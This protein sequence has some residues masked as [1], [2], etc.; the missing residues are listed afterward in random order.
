MISTPRRDPSVPFD[1]IDSHIVTA[2]CIGVWPEYTLCSTSIVWADE[3]LP[4]VVIQQ[5][6][7]PLRSDNHWKF[8]L[9]DAERSRANNSRYL[10]RGSFASC[11]TL[12]DRAVVISTEGN[13]PLICTRHC[14]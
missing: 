8:C 10:G 9:Q 14:Q 2:Y 7:K 12:G 3:G 13:I 5:T 1:S 4:C 6:L 11:D